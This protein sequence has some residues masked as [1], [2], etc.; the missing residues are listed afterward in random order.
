LRLGT[1]VMGGRF[2]PDTGVGPQNQAMDYVLFGA[3]AVFRWEDRL[4]VQCEYA[5]RNSDRFG[6]IPAPA[7]F[8]ERVGGCYVEAEA[9]LSRRRHL[10]IV[11]R[12]DIQS[13]QSL[14]PPPG[15]QLPGGDFAVQRFTYGVN[16]T[17]PGGSLLMVNHEH[18]FLPDN[19][20]SADVIGFRWALMF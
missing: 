9:L 8:Q 20:R 14:L 19:L 18:W 12:Y 16:W 5:Q 7:M 13:R 6:N 3:D 15:S 1:S 17:L 4:R 11:A 10:N 2:G